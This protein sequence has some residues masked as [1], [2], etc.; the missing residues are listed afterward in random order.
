MKNVMR[1]F[2][3]DEDAVIAIQVIMFSVMLLTASGMVIDFGRAYSA[4]SQMQGFVDKAALAAASELDGEA[5]AIARATEAANSV[6][7]TS[8]FVDS[9]AFEIK[10]IVF[11]SGN[12][13]DEGAFDYSA[14]GRDN[15]TAT[16]DTDAKYVLV[17]AAEA[18]V[19]LSLLSMNIGGGTGDVTDVAFTTYAVARYEEA[20]CGGLT[21]LVMCNPFEDTGESFHDAMS[22]QVGAMMKLTTDLDITAN[23]QLNNSEGMIRVGLLANPADEIGGDFAGICGNANLLSTFGGTGFVETKTNG[24]GSNWDAGAVGAM[25]K[26]RDMCMLAMLNSDIQCLSSDVIVKPTTPEVVVTGL[27]TAF[28]IWDEPLD[29]VLIDNSLQPHFA[30]DYVAVH[31]GITREELGLIAQEMAD[32]YYENLDATAVADSTELSTLEALEAVVEARQTQYD[33]FVGAGFPTTHPIVVATAQQL[34]MAIDAYDR[35]A[36]SIVAGEALGA[37]EAHWAAAAAA[38]ADVVENEASRVNHIFRANASWGPL[39]RASCLNSEPATCTGLHTNIATPQSNFAEYFASYYYPTRHGLSMDLDNPATELESRIAGAG[40]YYQGYQEVERVESMLWATDASNGYGDDYDYV[41]TAPTFYP[42]ASNAYDTLQS[43]EP[44]RKRI[45]VINCSAMDTH[46]EYVGYS[47]PNYAGT[48]VASVENV[49]DV[50]LTEAADVVEC[51]PGTVSNDPW[52]IN[53][54][55]NHEI[56]DAKIY[57]EFI[58]MASNGTA[59]GMTTRSYAVLVH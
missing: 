3:V 19:R 58:G 27:N 26:L 23:P 49:V 41:G 39:Y 50:Y 33:T 15:L 25:E 34:Q 22:G 10:E 8:N 52:G 37:T 55:W 14:I 40:T 30:P 16:V 9:G 6:S 54:C 57:A 35:E 38:Y 21:N 7:L 45:A 59:S 29:R 11:M 4:H 31:G 2:G 51:L 46:A 12:P 42:F 17:I 13:E 56:S 48:Y 1:R 5:G 44:R 32:A 20:I 24:V 18:S 36:A 28:D 43:E 53:P 47:D